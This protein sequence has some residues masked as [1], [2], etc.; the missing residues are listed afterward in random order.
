MSKEANVMSPEELWNEIEKYHETLP[1]SL[2]KELYQKILDAKLTRDEALQVINEAIRRYLSSLVAPGEAVGM[3]AAQSLGEPATQMTLRTFH[4]AG[5]RELNVTLGLPRLIEIVDLRREPSTPLMEIYLDPSHAKD[6]DFA[7]KIAKEIELT[8]I[9]NLC[10]T[11]TID[12]YQ[13]A[14]IMEFDPEMMENR[15]VTFEDVESALEKVKGKKGRI[16]RE[17]NTVIFYTGLEELTKLRRMYDRVLG[18]R[19]KGIKGIK[20]AIVKPVRDDNGELVEYVILTEGSN[21]KAVLGIEG[22]DPTRTTTN[23]IME[24]YEV[25]GIEAARNAIIK[26]IKR[27]LDD[28]GLDVDYRHIMMVADAMTYSGKVRQVGRHGVAGEKGSVLARASFE[29]TVKNLVEAALRGEVDELR[30]VIENVIIGSR[31]IPLGTGAV[32]LKMRYEFPKQ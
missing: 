2:R 29:V 18:L 24:I 27:V 26:E 17:G 4:F 13:F 12:F 28:H 9:E 21:L 32:K 11:I 22:V 19:I 25:L 10:N 15:G 31:P 23:N 20:H 6:L 1:L 16:E 30:G 7:L 3:V 14:I 8:T 5:V